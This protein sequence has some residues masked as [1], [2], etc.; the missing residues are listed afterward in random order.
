MTRP[1]LTAPRA[2]GE[3]LTADQAA[4]RLGVRKATLYAYVSRGL[5]TKIA[6]PLRPRCS[7]YAGVEL[8]RLRAGHHPA[9]R[10][11]PAEEATLYDGLPLVPTAL[12]G[13]VDGVLVVRGR[14]LETLARQASLEEMAAWLWDTEVGAAFD[15]PAP[16]LPALWHDTARALRQADPAARALTLWSL[17]MPQLQGG[18][19]LQGRGLAV[20]LGQHLR[21][22]VACWLGK[23]PTQAPLHL[24]VARAWRLPASSH[25]PLRQALVLCAD[26]VGNLMSLSTRMAASV[27]GSLATCL[28]A[29]M[30]YGFV[31]LS[32]GEFE[33]VEAL[34]DEVEATGS[35]S[36]VAASYRAR[37]EALPGIH[38]HLF[39]RGDP[40]GA[41]MLQLATAMGSKAASG[42]ASAQDDTPLLPALDFGLVALRR[43]IG[44]PRHAGLALTHMARQC[45]L[46]AQA[47]EQRQQPRRMWVQSR[48]VG[49]ATAA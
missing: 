4:A 35:F 46:L 9:Q 47:L 28:L 44:A 31:R 48:Y 19:D 7:R 21:V 30:G 11:A 39:V 36:R 17:A 10:A 3:L 23:A 24:Q 42:L 38:H 2:D 34:F 16:M 43:V 14:P 41:L 6:D 22:A 15:A 33:A 12:S 27:Q 13:L 8:D 49:P 40:R 26:M 29:G 32:G 18:I 25:E 37:G 20:A 1:I 45:G 5:L